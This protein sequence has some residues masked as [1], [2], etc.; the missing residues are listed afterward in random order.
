MPRFKL[1]RN[2]PAINR[3]TLDFERYLTERPRD[4]P[5]ASIELATPLAR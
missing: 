3:P 2:R 5:A 4:P 1:G